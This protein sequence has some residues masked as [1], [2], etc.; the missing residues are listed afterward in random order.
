MGGLK[1]IGSEKLRGDDKIKRIMEIAQY[2]E[3]Q[4]NKEYHVET[5]SFTKTG[6]DGHTYAIVQER[7]GYYLKSGLNESS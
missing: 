5:T 1:P 4:K 3:V 6:A 7:D 2:G